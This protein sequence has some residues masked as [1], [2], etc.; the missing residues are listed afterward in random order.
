MSITQSLFVLTLAIFGAASAN[1]IANGNCIVISDQDLVM[2]E[3]KPGQEFPYYVYMIPKGTEYDDQRWILESTNDGYFKLKNKFSGRYLV[4]GTFDYFLTAGAAVR[5]M[6]HFKF[7]ADGTGK[8][9]ISSKANGHPRSRG[10]NWGVMKDGVEH[11]F[12][13]ENCQE[14]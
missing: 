9:D 1:P 10:K 8:Y 5:A 12:T 3:R 11:Y 6:D 14:T 4:Y 7:T 13:V 2:H